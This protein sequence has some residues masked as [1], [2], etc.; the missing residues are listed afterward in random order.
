M[1][2]VRRDDDFGH[3]DTTYPWVGKLIADHFVE[4][5]A[6]AFG[7]PLMTVGVQIPGYNSL[8]ETRAVFVGARRSSSPASNRVF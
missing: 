6:D 5:F 7:D 8:R 1:A 4:F 2:K 3:R